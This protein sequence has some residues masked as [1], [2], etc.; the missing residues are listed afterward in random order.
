LA[1]RLKNAK[2]RGN[3]CVEDIDYRAARGLDKNV[4]RALTQQSTWVKNH[5]NIFVLGPTGVESF[6]ASALARKACRDGFSA[7]YTRAAAL[8][9]EL[10]LARAD[11]RF[12]HLFVR[13]SRIDVLV[14]DDWQCAAHGNGTPGFLGD[15]RGTPPNPQ[16]DLDITN[17][18]GALARTDWRSDSC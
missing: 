10:Y 9:R 12:R 6:I 17:A 15:L 7:L 13:I 16:C 4:M 11:G 1:R 5:E 3:P 14:V 8:F 2:L 18:G